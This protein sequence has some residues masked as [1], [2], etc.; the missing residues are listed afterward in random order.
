MFLKYL[1]YFNVLWDGNYGRDKWRLLPVPVTTIH[2]PHT[3]TC[4][5]QLILSLL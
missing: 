3:T 5:I 4:L 1:K 2:D